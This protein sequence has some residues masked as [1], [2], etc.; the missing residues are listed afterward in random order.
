[1]FSTGAILRELM[2]DDML[3]NG[4]KDSYG[5]TFAPD[6]EYIAY[7]NSLPGA[8]AQATPKAAKG[9]MEFGAVQFA[10]RETT[11]GR[12]A[13]VIEDDILDGIYSGGKWTKD[14]LR[15]AKARVQKAMHYSGAVMSQGIPFYINAKTRN[16]LAGSS[17]AGTYIKKTPERYADHQRTSANPKE[18][19][20]ATTGWK[21]DSGLN[22]ETNSGFV[23]YAHGFVLI[24]VHGRRYQAQTVAGITAERRYVLYDLVSMKT[25]SFELK[26]EASSPREHIAKEAKD[27]VFED[28]SNDG[29]I[30]HSPRSVKN[31]PDTDAYLQLYDE[32]RTARREY[33][34]AR[35]EADAAGRNDEFIDAGMALI[36]YKGS[37]FSEEGRAEYQRLKQNM[38]DIAERLGINRLAE[39][40]NELQ[41]RVR[42]LEKQFEE[43]EKQL[44]VKRETEAIKK[45]GLTPAEYYRKQAV[46]EFGYTTDF[47]DAGYLLPDGKML[48][49]SGEKGKHFGIRGQDHRAIGVIYEGTSGTKALT[50]FVSDGNIRVMAESPG[51]DI[52]AGFLRLIQVAALRRFMLIQ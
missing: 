29:I 22:Y 49:F 32:L 30:Q 36:N 19:I 8:V 1:M 26:N 23:N 16:H 33:E 10:V 35:R 15:E 11:D 18:L 4:Y 48:N 6:T 45:S 24:D 5:N 42:N 41:I 20:L 21:D 28:A 38:Q 9:S 7:K 12:K 17:E 27:S 44:A 50:R 34:T 14:Q 40:A 52:A 31:D 43:A 51:V 25:A 2:L 13:L 39:H 37:R 3:S 46:K 47:V